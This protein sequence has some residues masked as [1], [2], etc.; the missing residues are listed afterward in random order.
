MFCFHTIELVK[1][2]CTPGWLVDRAI[3]KWRD[4]SRRCTHACVAL[5]INIILHRHVVA[6]ENKALAGVTLRENKIH[7]ATSSSSMHAF[8]APE[9]MGRSKWR[10]VPQQPLFFLAARTRHADGT[11][12]I[13][14]VRIWL[15]RCFLS[16][17]F[18]SILWFQKFSR[19]T[20]LY[21]MIPH[22]PLYSLIMVFTICIYH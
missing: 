3:R 13:Y 2:W 19:L 7:V 12:I 15:A 20:I 14:V 18:P 9:N 10:H 4:G 6:G 17:D 1:R 11:T 21:H 5:Y 8:T 16:W 22:S